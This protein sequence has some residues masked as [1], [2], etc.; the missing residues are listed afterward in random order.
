V[1][2]W[3]QYSPP[4]RLCFSPTFED[5]AVLSLALYRMLLRF[6]VSQ[7]SQL[8]YACCWRTIS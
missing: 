1:Q 3:G 6:G 7:F 2:Y 4:L 5:T 8:Q